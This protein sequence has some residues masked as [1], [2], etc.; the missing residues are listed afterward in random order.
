MKHRV[1]N[2]AEI[3]ALEAKVRSAAE[4]LPELFAAHSGSG[5]ELVR[6]M[7]FEAFGR[8]PMTGGSLN[9]IE[10]VNQTFAMLVTLRAARLLLEWH[11]DADG[12]DL[13][14][15][16]HP[17][18][19]ILSVAPGLV[20]GEA[21]AAVEPGSND[22][23]KKDCIKMAACEAQHRYVFFNAPGHSEGPYKGNTPV[24]G[25]KVWAVSV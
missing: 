9:L 21:F 17:G 8:H 7:K 1:R 14:L 3:E 16:P 20:A 2:I 13:V 22:K 18:I 15:G 24:A 4:A 6:R 5:L 11:P 25:V 10:Q 19:D 23:L 12:F